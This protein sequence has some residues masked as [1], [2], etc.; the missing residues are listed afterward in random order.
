MARVSI[1]YP[2]GTK[3]RLGDID[4]TITAIF[5]RGK[6]RAYEF[7]YVHDGQPTSCNVEEVEIEPRQKN[8]F[9]FNHS[10]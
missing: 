3:V 7:S 1:K 8:S 5:I 6:G 2:Y 4:G 10:C 9:G